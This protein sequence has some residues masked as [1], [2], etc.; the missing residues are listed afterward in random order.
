MATFPLNQQFEWQIIHLLLFHIYKAKAIDNN[1][2]MSN[3][4][5]SDFRD[6]T[7]GEHV[8]T[9]EF[10]FQEDVRKLSM[11]GF[12][13][14]EQLFY[15]GWNQ[16]WAMKILLPNYQN[17]NP[18]FVNKISSAIEELE[19]IDKYKNVREKVKEILM[20]PHYP[21]YFDFLEY[22]NSIVMNIVKMIQPEKT[23]TIYQ[24]K[25]YLYL[26]LP[27]EFKWMVTAA[28]D[29]PGD[30]IKEDPHITVIN[31]NEFEKF[32]DQPEAL[33]ELCSAEIDDVDFYKLAGTYSEDY[34]PYENVVV[35]KCRSKKLEKALERLD[36]KLPEQG[37]FKI[38]K[39]FHFTIWNQ[40]RPSLI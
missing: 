2:R 24:N 14:N 31:S 17:M 4:K 21:K 6:R 39:E 1:I 26:K 33:E 22:D 35:A 37:M 27:D 23:L 11:N 9:I 18:E 16:I 28:I 36:A 40:E 13:R 34:P 12:D 38:I 25:V 3:K 8:R 29:E 19:H 32:K 20:Y 7:L 10:R 15:N 5:I 30:S